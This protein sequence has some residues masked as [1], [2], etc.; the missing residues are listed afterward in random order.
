MNKDLKNKS[1]E[2]K[3]GNRPQRSTRLLDV[4]AFTSPRQLA[5]NVRFDVFMAVTVKNAVFRVMFL[6]NIS[7][8]KTDTAYFIWLTDC[9]E[10]PS[11]TY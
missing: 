8:Y 7:S 9:S 3:K 1:K 11:L 10:V 2:K 5:Y 6:R 4:E